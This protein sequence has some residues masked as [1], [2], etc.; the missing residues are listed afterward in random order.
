MTFIDW[1]YASG[2][3]V[4]SLGGGA[5]LVFGFSSWLGK[6]WATRILQKEKSQM[7][8]LAFQFQTRFSRPD[9]KQAQLI[10]ELYGKLV[11]VDYGVKQVTYWMN[12]EPI[13]KKWIAEASLKLTDRYGLLRSHFELNQIYFSESLCNQLRSI[14][15]LSSEVSDEY[16]VRLIDREGE[17]LDHQTKI[18]N[19]FVKDKAQ[20]L[21]EAIKAVEKEF[22]VHLGVIQN[23]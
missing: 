19:E 18:A 12:S 15:E 16:F 8:Q 10:A 13:N 6:V 17:S 3:F 5:A 23:G 1:L 22:R 2:A 7:E 4:T 21:Y 20:K 9:E 14:L 11:E